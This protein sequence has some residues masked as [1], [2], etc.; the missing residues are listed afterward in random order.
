MA[1]VNLSLRFQTANTGV[2]NEVL[3]GLQK[4]ESKTL[5]KFKIQLDSEEFIKNL[6]A[7]KSA[8]GRLG[9]DNGLVAN[10]NSV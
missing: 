2:I 1:E 7:L 10:I 3:E 9:L 5:K 8:I 6:N 4:I